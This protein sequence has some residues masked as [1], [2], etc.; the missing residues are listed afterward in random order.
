MKF[1]IGLFSF[2]CAS[3]MSFTFSSKLDFRPPGTAEIVDNFFYDVNEITN[4]SWKE[5]LSFI[6]ESD[7]VDSERYKANLPD[8]MVWME[9]GSYNEPLVETYFSHPSYDYYPVVGITHKQATDYCTWRTEAVK[10]MLKANGIEGPKSFRY[11]LPSQ[12]EWSLMANAG[13][14]KKSKRLIAKQ[15]KKNAVPI[16]KITGNFRFKVKEGDKD[17]FNDPH[18]LKIPIPSPTFLPNK[19]GVYNIYGNVAEMVTEPGIAM[20]GSFNHYYE[21]IVPENKIISYNSPEKWLGF[22]CVCEILEK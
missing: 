13:M 4:I 8:T 21:D 17:P 20:G 10:T 22:R 14:S 19:Y 5:Y 6:K 15:A 11:R 18:I 3:I 1:K 9:E 16:K 2:V 7:G 12:T